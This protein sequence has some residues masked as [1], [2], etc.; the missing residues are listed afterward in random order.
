MIKN[1]KTRK[2]QTQSKIVLLSR[3]RS[4]SKGAF[5]AMKKENN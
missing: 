5:D 1:V 4:V 3:T 2:S